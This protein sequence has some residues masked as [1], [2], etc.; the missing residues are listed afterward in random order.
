MTLS[1]ARMLVDYQGGS[2]A[3]QSSVSY[4]IAVDEGRLSESG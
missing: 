1:Q 3:K 4:I 2:L